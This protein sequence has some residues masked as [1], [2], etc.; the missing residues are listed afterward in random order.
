MKFDFC[1]YKAQEMIRQAAQLA[2]QG[3][4]QA[5]EAGHLLKAILQ[6][7]TETCTFLFDKCGA[8]LPLLS[9]KLD[10]VMKLYPRVT[11]GDP[12]IG[13]DASNAIRRARGLL[14]EFND[15]FVSVE[16]LLLGLLEGN[17]LAAKFMHEAGL[18]S[19]AVKEAIK[20]L[21]GPAKTVQSAS[22]DKSY[23]ALLRYGINL[24]ERAQQGG[25][26]PVVGRDEEVRRLLQILSRRGKNNPVLVGE[27]GVGKTAIVEGLARRIVQG[28]VPA[29]LADKTIVSLDMGLLMAGASYKGEFEERLKAVVQEVAASNGSVILFIDEIHTLVGTGSGN[30]SA[31]DAANLLKPA[32]ARGELRTIGATTLDEYQKYIEKD[33]AL[34]RRF[35]PVRVN[36]PDIDDAISILRGVKEKFELHH[37]VLIQDDAIIAAVELSA[38]YINDRY[39]PDK[40]IDLIDEAGAKLRIET[41]ALPQELDALNRR[42]VKLEIERE[43]IRREK[44]TQKEKVLTDTLADLTAQRDERLGQWEREKQT[45]LSIRNLKS[46]LDQYRTDVEQSERQANYARLAELRYQL[47]PDA[48]TRLRQLT[49]EALAAPLINEEVTPAEIA[50]IVTRWTG[51]PASRMLQTEQQKLQDLD[52]ELAQRVAGQ[53]AAI[54]SVANAVRRSRTGLQDPKRPIGSF[55]FL[56]PTGV[57]KTELAKA[58]GEALFNNEQSLVRIDMSEYQERQTVSRLIGAAPGLVG[59]DEAGQ[60]TEAVR[61]KPYSIVLLDEIEKAHPDVWNI[62]LQI[63]D[64]GRLTDNKGRVVDF[65]NTIVI[66]TANL[67]SAIIR[68]NALQPATDERALRQAVVQELQTVMRPEFI[69]RIDEIVLFNPLSESVIEQILAGQLKQLQHRL[70]QQELHLTVSPEAYQKLAAEGYDPAF[71]ARPLKRVVQQRVIDPLAHLLVAGNVPAD[72]MVSLYVDVDDELSVR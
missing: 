13:L 17:D 35:Q 15:E 58:L 60:L 62:L 20:S 63:L 5:I 11:G 59:Y 71:G 57:G 65:K 41:E 19:N 61:R 24:T 32:L 51:I 23:Q 40:A 50:A 49:A 18:R 56:G 64:D 46:L 9:E 7:D 72:R 1:T 21:R 14:T 37:G 12:F 39:L 8:R 27:P 67:G 70:E 45:L 36:E 42:I 34:E 4:Q 33:K 68:A 43:A 52:S 44:K 69:N 10:A 22:A 38:R 26:D 25:I 6:H 48:E 30:N 54:R 31:L 16:L 28:D 3:G 2:K 53:P 29:V 47:I 66:M 55:L